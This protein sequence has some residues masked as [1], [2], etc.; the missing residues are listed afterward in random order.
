MYMRDRLARL[1]GPDPH[2]TAKPRADF[3]TAVLTPESGME[4]SS[5]VIDE[6]EE[7]W[8]NELPAWANVAV[9]TATAE[10]RKHTAPGS[11][12]APAGKIAIPAH[13]PAALQPDR[14]ALERRKSDRGPP[15]GL[16]DRRQPRAF[17][18]R[19]AH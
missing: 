8:E 12:V 13:D 16:P 4:P 19:S 5:A 2:W 18:R 11:A 6:E 10:R 17:G 9:A 14:N 3:S 15:P 7:D 1:Y